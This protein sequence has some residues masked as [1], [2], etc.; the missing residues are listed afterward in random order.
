MESGGQKL[1]VTAGKRPVRRTSGTD[2]FRDALM[3]WA[4]ASWFSLF[5]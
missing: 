1:T 5:A 3:L 2:F 4:V